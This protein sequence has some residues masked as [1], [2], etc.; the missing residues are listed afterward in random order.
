MARSTSLPAR[1]KRSRYV[2]A[3]MLGT[4]LSGL[5]AAP[6][7]AG[8]KADSDS[9]AVQ[10]ISRYC[11]ACWRNARLHPDSW[12]DCTQEVLCRL[13][14]RVELNEWPRLLKDEGDERR[15]FLRAIDAVKKRSQR[16]RRWA[17]IPADDAMADRAAA[18]ERR[19]KDDRQAM[20][21]AIDH[22]L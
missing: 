4:A 1:P 17:P 2:V 20:Y 14:E 15:E 5:G 22:L 8:A 11:T 10:D 3:M 6:A 19:L 12:N 18:H 16:A 21:Q 13:L 9:R 7:V